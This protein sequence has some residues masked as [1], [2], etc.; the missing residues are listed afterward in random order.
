MK[1]T[2]I[3][4]TRFTPIK[5]KGFF[6]TNFGVYHM[7]NNQHLGDCLCVVYRCNKQEILEDHLLTDCLLI[8]IKSK[9]NLQEIHTHED[10]KKSRIFLNNKPV[11]LRI[12]SECLFGSFGDTHC[13]C[14]SH[15][16]S[17][18]K[19]IRKHGE[20]IFIS[21]PQDG[22]GN[23]LF[24]KAKELELQVNGFLPDGTFVG[25]KNISEAAK[26]LLGDSRLLEKRN[27]TSLKTVIDELGLNKYQFSLISGNPTKRKYLEN[28]LG[29]KVSSLHKIRGDIKIDNIGEYLSKLY[30][31]N[32]TLTDEELKEIY[33]VI[34]S[35]KEIP[36]RA[37]SVLRFIREDLKLGKHF[38]V[39]HVLLNKLVALL[40]TKFKIQSIEDLDFFKDSKAYD[41]F[42][43]ELQ[44]DEDVLK[45][46]FESDILIEDEALR[47]EENYF[48]ELP[49]FSLIPCRTLKIRKAF[50][51]N[52]LKHPII[53]ELIYKIPVEDKR[54]II[55]CIKIEQEDIINL[56]DMSL[57]D[58]NVHFL[59]VF[60]HTLKSSYSNIKI[61][62]KRYSKE[63]RVLSLMGEKN[64]V[65]TLVSEIKKISQVKEI[66]SL[67]DYDYANKDINLDFNWKKLS[68]EEMTIFKKYFKG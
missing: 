14:E 65:N 1:K 24:Y 33:K 28:N 16:I 19:E 3:Q 54:H 29:I 48:Y 63:L 37:A 45:N 51:L 23:G 11:L 41:E 13:D 20:G 59:P 52:D 15:R 53:S 2:D 22:Q 56:I 5:L 49:Y 31:K 18:L 17:S 30:S 46:L 67:S 47:Y 44:L 4:N 40:D 57:K 66:E 10:I 26:I 7:K 25:Q 8:I 39:D 64:K 42:H 32:F 38:H 55:R 34:S 12:S 35:S 9:I 36:E 61:L 27:Y 43:I 60:T 50:R 6:E 21:L 62:M 68:A 58:H